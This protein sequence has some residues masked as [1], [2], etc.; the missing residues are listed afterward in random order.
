MHMRE[1]PG[2]VGKYVRDELGK[3]LHKAI[4]FIIS[5]GILSYALYIDYDMTVYLDG[6][7]SL[8]K[9][10]T[11][12]LEPWGWDKRTEFVLRLFNAEKI[13]I[14][15]EL[16]FVVD[17]ALS[18]FSFTVRFFRSRLH[19]RRRQTA[20]ETETATAPTGH[21]TEE[22]RMRIRPN[23]H[24]AVFLF[25]TAAALAIVAIAAM[26]YFGGYVLP[27]KIEIPF[28]V[29][30]SVFL[31]AF[32]V[33][34]FVGQHLMSAAYGGGRIADIVVSAPMVILSVIAA[35]V[36]LEIPLGKSIVTFVAEQLGLTV[37]LTR[38]EY[39][40]AAWWFFTIAAF[41]D[42]IR[43]YFGVG[44]RSQWRP[45]RSSPPIGG[46]DYAIDQRP[47]EPLDLHSE[48]GRPFFRTEGQLLVDVPDHA[49]VRLPNGRM[50]QFPLT[51]RLIDRM[52]FNMVR[53]QPQPVG[54]PN[55]APRADEGGTD[56]DNT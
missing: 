17:I 54:L 34:Y 37:D 10:I 30:P 13:L 6:N 22:R 55:N 32:A 33:I 51:E 26:I 12:W 31:A 47:H 35:M 45:G 23:I 56:A 16:W 29:P 53:R 24:P 8:I 36:W 49:I 20:E 15:S 28:A 2:R 39:K 11:S 4:S 18:I 40:E 5:F 43:D 3:G 52:E 41:F 9:W 46:Q 19:P 48:S 21:T 7:I 50:F 44:R 1:V 38:T 42:I 25:Y 27:I 14:F